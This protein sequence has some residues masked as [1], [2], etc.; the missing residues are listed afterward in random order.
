MHIDWCVASTVLSALFCAAVTVYRT[1]KP[2]DR[3]ATPA[4]KPTDAVHR[5]AA[6]TTDGAPLPDLYL[7]DDDRE[8]NRKWKALKKRSNAGHW[9]L[10]HARHGKR[11]SITRHPTI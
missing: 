2:R 7:G 10:W 6:F 8:C 3:V 1:G 11:D 5:I 9:E 4:A